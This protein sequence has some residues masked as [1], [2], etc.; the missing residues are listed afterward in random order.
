MKCKIKHHVAFKNVFCEFCFVFVSN[1]D[2]NTIF[3]SITTI[4]VETSPFNKLS[5]DHLKRNTDF[6]CE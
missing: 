4:T 1:F 2:R 5:L 3:A 6:S